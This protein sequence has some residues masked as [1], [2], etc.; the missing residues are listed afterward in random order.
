[1]EMNKPKSYVTEK[2]LGHYGFTNAM[3]DNFH[4]V[5]FCI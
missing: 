1:M 2:Q 4:Y 5:R 3:P